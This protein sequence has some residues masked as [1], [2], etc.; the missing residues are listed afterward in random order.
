M[1]NQYELKIE[2]S[3]SITLDIQSE[4]SLLIKNTKDL[5]QDKH[6]KIKSRAKKLVISTIISDCFI[7][8]M[9]IISKIIHMIFI[10]N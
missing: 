7:I 5:I 1:L 6:K 4:N 8:L 9:T 10:I 2:E 3:N